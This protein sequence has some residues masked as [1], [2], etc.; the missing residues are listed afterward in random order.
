MEFP[1]LLAAAA[2][3]PIIWVLRTYFSRPSKLDMPHLDLEGDKSRQRYAAESVTLMAQGHQ[4]HLKHGRPFSLRNIVDDNQ[5]L[6]VL[7]LKYLEEVK[8][9]PQDKLSFALFVEKNSILRDIHGPVMTDEGSHM[10]RSDL[11]RA[12]PAL[13]EP[14]RQQC[15]E[16][17][18]KVMPPCPD[19]NSVIPYPVFLQ[20]FVKMSSYVLASPELSQNDAWAGV[21]FQYISSFLKAVKSVRAR[22]NPSIR[23]LAKYVDSDVKEVDQHRKQAAELLR[24]ILEA[25]M[26]SR[27][28]G[29]VSENE[30][31]VQWLLDAYLSNGK[32]PK[33][34]EVVMDILGMSVSSVHS[35]SAT[36]LST[37]YDLIDHPDAL[38]SIR[39]EIRTV[40]KGRTSWDRSALNSLILL[41]S[42]MKESQR[43]HSVPELTVQRLAV[44]SWTFQDGLSIPA[45]TQIGFANRQINLDE[46]TH[47]GAHVFDAERF[48][49]KRRGDDANRYQFASVSSD[50][51]NFGAGAQACP[52]RFLAQDAIKLIFVHLLPNYDVK[53]VDKDQ[54]R[55]ADM[56]DNLLML[57]NF[58]T[59]IMFKELKQETR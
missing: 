50:S 31:G 44:N 4:K 11:N 45:G 36:L 10:V 27:A 3:I 39:E 49:R 26:R 37:L 16:T 12:L 7:P 15:L 57:P 41:D 25:R 43:I 1:F 28:D 54:R 21:T 42:F 51:I 47:K 5:P 8:A 14:M 6:V 29:T 33:A 38:A 24:P 13:I 48:S 52:G 30:D 23:W 59:P 35:S 18:S 19:W 34:E 58:A 56:P 17:F 46:D 20:A 55:P 2:T 53:Y 22:Y 40:S 9:A 32:K